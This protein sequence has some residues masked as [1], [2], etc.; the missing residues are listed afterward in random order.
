MEWIINAKFVIVLLLDSIVLKNH[1]YFFLTTY[2]FFLITEHVVEE[3]NVE[4]NIKKQELE[5]TK[6]YSWKY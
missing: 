2:N 1:R 4:M 6:L 5:Q 3:G